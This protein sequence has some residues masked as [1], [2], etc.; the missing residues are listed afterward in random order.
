VDATVAVEELALAVEPRPESA[1]SA[2]LGWPNVLVPRVG[3]KAV[4]DLLVVEK[5]DRQKS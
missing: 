5:K 3:E 1:A 2:H 4:S